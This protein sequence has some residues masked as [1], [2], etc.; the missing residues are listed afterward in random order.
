M[1]HDDF[2]FRAVFLVFLTGMCY[3]TSL[4]DTSEKYGCGFVC[5]VR[6]KQRVTEYAIIRAHFHW[7]HE[8]KFWA[9]VFLGNAAS[10]T[11]CRRRDKKDQRSDEVRAFQI[12]KNV[13]RM[14]HDNF[15]FAPC[16]LFSFPA[17]PT[18]HP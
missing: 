11:C 2:L 15:S 8:H 9:A 10:V 13:L 7:W 12:G 3:S 14:I 17:S 18:P 1:I 5:L 4:A 16:F 6:Q